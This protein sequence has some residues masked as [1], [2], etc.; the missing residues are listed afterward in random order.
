MTRRSVDP[1]RVQQRLGVPGAA[2]ESALATLSLF[3]PLRADEICRI[4]E[5]FLCRTL[6][7]TEALV[8]PGAQSWFFVVTSGCVQVDIDD[9]VGHLQFRLRTGDSYGLS[10]VLSDSS[11]RATLV[12]IEASTI[13]MIDRCGF[14]RVLQSFP[15]VALPLAREI[16]IDLRRR[17]DQLRQALDLQVAGLPAPAA[18][19]ALS[20]LKRAMTLRTGGVRRLNT[21][22][23][24]RR[25]V[26]EKGTE[27]PFWIVIGFGAGLAGSRLVVHAILKYHLEAHLFALVKGADPNPVHIHHFNY[28]LVLVGVAGLVSLF[29][30]GRRRLRGL[31]LLYGLG[32]AL[33]FDEFALFWNL[34][35]NY[36]QGL[37]LISAGIAAALLVQLA[38]FRQFWTALFRRAV[39]Q[40][41]SE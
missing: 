23:L 30:N 15:A 19:R 11:P 16:A 36:S 38:F 40:L 6:A 21:S 39:Q 20:Q 28:G 37:S 4:R 35:P 33:V 31:S 12:A 27:P 3:E 18:A 26:V 5:D 14:E 1:T 24:F 34:D 32:A 29:P 9:P 22:G 10:G 17:N 2:L 7:A 25:W 8:A 13:A 41:G